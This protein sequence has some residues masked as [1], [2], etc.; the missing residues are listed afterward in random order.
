[1]QNPKLLDRFNADVKLQCVSNVI[2]R[3][4]IL[5]QVNDTYSQCPKCGLKFDPALPASAACPACGIYVL[6]WN[7]AISSP[8]LSELDDE[9]GYRENDSFVAALFKPMD[10][11]SAMAFYGRSVTLILLAIWS[12]FL[13]GYDYRYG[14]I[15][16]SFMHDILLPIHEAG[17][18]LFRPFG[19]FM[20]I[21]GSSLF[22]VALPF[23][24]SIAFILKNRDNFG[25]AIGLWLTSVSLVD[26]SPYIYDSLHPMLTLLGGKT[27][28]DGPHDWIYLLTTLGQLSNAQRW[29][30]FFHAVGGLL[31]LLALIWAGI[32]LWRQRMQL[33]DR[34]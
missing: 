33:D 12:W 27:G 19:E 10:K 34:L 7:Q 24:I 8:E 1:M 4:I 25:A 21:L 26:V 9:S 15:N 31:M 3:P 2:S 16:M 14:E 5:N 29:G 18:V 22:Q 23:G 13:F 17:H 28:A 11:L 32:M 20:M 30:A 6:K